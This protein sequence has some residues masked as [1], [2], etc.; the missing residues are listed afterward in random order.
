[1]NLTLRMPTR[2]GMARPDEIVR[3]ALTALLG[4]MFAGSALA[5][6]VAEITGSDPGSRM[7]VEF[8]GDRLRI[9][10]QAQRDAEGYMIA[11]EGKVYA[12]TRQ[13]GKPMVIDVG[14]M[15]QML[16]PML[17]Q[18]APPQTFDDVGEFKGIRALGRKETVA[19][20]EGTVHEVVYVTRDGREERTEMVLSRDSRLIEMGRAMMAMGMAFQK[21]LGQSP[22]PGSEV[23][24]RQLRDSG[25]GVLRFGN[26]YKLLSLS[27]SAP[28]ASRFQLPAE[29]MAMPAIGGLPGLSPNPA[30]AGAGAQTAPQQPSSGFS[31]PGLFGGKVE[32]QTERVENKVDRQVDSATDK[33]V[34]KVL[35]RALGRILGR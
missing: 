20:I 4:V 30:A 1:M 17:K 34:D 23:L 6:G 21:S 31:L 7:R 14:A 11:R 27:G 12:V 9:D 19:G 29:P 28:D 3:V 15:M 13:D 5:A 24:E 26:D 8:D 10:P 18:M 33:A 22:S 16:G 32:R 2:L 35:E 25:E